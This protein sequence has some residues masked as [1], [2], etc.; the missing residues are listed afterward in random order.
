MRIL[1]FSDIHIPPVLSQVPVS[2]WFSK[3]L[4]GAANM[5]LLRGRHFPGV[6]R[7][8]THL[9]AFARD[10]EVDLALCTGD[11]TVLGTERELA[12]AR[13]RMQPFVDLPQGL[14]V[15]PGNHDRYA[16]DT[17]REERFQ[18]H[19]GDLLKSD[20]PEDAGV[21][22]WPLVRF[23]GSGVA[24]VA[25]DGAV[26]HGHPLHA[27]GQIPAPQLTRLDQILRDGRLNGRFIFVLVHHAP[28]RPDGGP[29][30]DNH[31]L[32]NA[33]ALLRTCSGIQRGAILFGHVHHCFHL[34]VPG[35]QAH[36]FGAGSTTMLGSEGGWVFDVEPSTTRVTRIRYHHGRYV[37][38]I[39]SQVEM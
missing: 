35:C 18:N 4:V 38:D 31:G 1:H 14:I 9:A 28:R 7:K 2:D 27:W 3:R 25:L 23:P 19:F 29:D 33:D 36:L 34:Q 32:R 12:E 30:R 15:V 16:P 13:E 22:D 26:A 6:R 20:W 37:L 21:I 10:E 11:F 5:A 17:V 8:L 39:K 24:V